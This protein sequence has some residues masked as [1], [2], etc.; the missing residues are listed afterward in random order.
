MNHN[1]NNNNDE[2]ENT[3]Y[4]NNYKINNRQLWKL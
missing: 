4:V 3:D 1:K 2:N